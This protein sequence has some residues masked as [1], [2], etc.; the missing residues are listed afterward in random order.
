MEQAELLRALEAAEKRTAA[1]TEF[2]CFTSTKVQILTL[3]GGGRAGG[4]A[5]VFSGTQFT[6]FTSPKVQIL[7]LWTRVRIRTAAEALE[8]EVK[9]LL[10]RY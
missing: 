10:R 4:S 1:G 2:T 5:C 7:S 3:C 8:R 6:C 9:A